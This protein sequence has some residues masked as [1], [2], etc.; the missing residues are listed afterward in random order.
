M[1]ILSDTDLSNFFLDRLGYQLDTCG[2]KIH[3]DKNYFKVK[4]GNYI[5]KT[6]KDNKIKLKKGVFYLLT[7]KEDIYVTEDQ[8][9]FVHGRSTLGRHGIFIHFTAGLIDPGFRGKIT[10]EVLSY[11]H[12][13][14]LDLN[15]QIGV[16]VYHKLETMCTKPYQFGQHHYMYQKDVT[17]PYNILKKQ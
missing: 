6:A 2:I 9:A 1:T 10:L 12:D 13:Y 14:V 16:I 17:L 7:T 3:P 5:P 4:N 11:D 8:C 15:E